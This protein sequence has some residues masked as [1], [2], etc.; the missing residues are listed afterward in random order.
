MDIKE[1][2]LRVAKKMRAESEWDVIDLVCNSENFAEAL[3]AELAKQNKPVAELLS[4]F[5]G[6]TDS[7]IKARAIGVDPFNT[8]AFPHPGTKLYT[9]PP[10]AEQIA[11]ETAEAIAEYMQQ[12]G[13]GGE[14]LA[15]SI[16][17]GEWRK[18]VKEV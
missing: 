6:K 2:A 8:W 5:P 17:S 15:E 18:F 7:Y 11:N 12:S 16:R 9:Y 10:T 4:L 13:I 3:I 14:F 1:I